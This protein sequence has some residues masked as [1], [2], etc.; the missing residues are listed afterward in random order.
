[1]NNTLIGCLGVG[2]AVL[3]SLQTTHAQ[4]SERPNVIF[5]LADDSVT[6]I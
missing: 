3:S 4:Q 2:A 6:E 1:M 5:I